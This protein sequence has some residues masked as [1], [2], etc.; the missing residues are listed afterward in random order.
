M[1]SP[2]RL[3]STLPDDYV[4]RLN[5]LRIDDRFYRRLIRD[6]EIDLD[7]PDGSPLLRFRK[8]VLSFHNANRAYPAL[9][10]AAALSVR[11]GNVR[12]GIIGYY[13]APVCRTTAF[14]AQDVRGW[15]SVLPFIKEVND[16][17]RRELPSRYAAQMDAAK[18]TPPQFVIPGTC[19]STVTVNRNWRTH[20]HKDAGD[21][22]EGFG[23][24]AVLDAGQY[25]GGYL[26][27]PKYEVAV[28]V[29]LGDLLLYD[30]HEAHG[31]AP[32][33]GAPGTFERISTVFYFRTGMLGCC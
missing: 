32:L 4:E 9:L 30:V 18:R 15:F 17:F 16:V 25:E 23:C 24:L 13:D 22:P 1:N 20:V 29:R 11:R 33:I 10:K 12:S 8:N 21:L 31:N 7:K 5:G 2:L 3:R 27:L 14:T 19:F 26:I 6:E 28:D